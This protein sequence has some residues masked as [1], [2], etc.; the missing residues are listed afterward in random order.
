MRITFAAILAD[1]WALF[2]RD[3][4]LLLRIAGLFFFV[5]TYALVLLVAPFPVPDPAIA[6]RQAQG[7]AW[8]TA[9]DGWM[10]DYGFGCVAAYLV[11]YFGMAVVFALLL[12]RD[13]PTLAGAL[14]RV[15]GLFPRFLLA[16]IVVSIP[17]GAGMYIL[18]LPG[19]WLMSRFML[20]GAVLIAERPVG[21]MAAIGRSWR[22]TRRVQ[23]ALLGAIVTVYLGGLL[24]GQPFML[25]GRWLAGDGQANPVAVAITSGLAA[26]VAMLSQ[27]AGAMIAVA[28]YRRLVADQP[29][30]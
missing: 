16:M 5:P 7:Q 10:G 18:L 29:A 11:T 9:V 3:A 4:D 24:A 12:D 30:K 2:R 19:L 27:L 21:A 13:R 8:M 17:A 23:I 6:D 14:R 28:V 20:T 22:L 25:L 26:A 1:A 15:A